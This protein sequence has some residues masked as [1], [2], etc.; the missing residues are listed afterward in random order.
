MP[1]QQLKT[2]YHPECLE[3]EVFLSNGNFETFGWIGYKYKRM[4][5]RAYD[6][7]GKIELSC[8]SIFALR[9]EVEESFEIVILYGPGV[10]VGC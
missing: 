10:A 1:K 5:N 3:G 6:F 8:K 7:F 9:S 4:G 2:R